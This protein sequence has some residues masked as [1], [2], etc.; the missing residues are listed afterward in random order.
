MHLS[1][2]NAL[3]SRAPANHVRVCA[4][5][6]IYVIDH[7]DQTKALKMVTTR[8]QASL[9]ARVP[10]GPRR[11]VPRNQVSE[12]ARRLHDRRAQQA[13][14][15]KVLGPVHPARP[16]PAPAAPDHSQDDRTRS[17]IQGRMVQDR[18][19]VLAPEFAAARNHHHQL[20][21]Q[22]LTA[23]PE[24]QRLED[25]LRILNLII[26]GHQTTL[27]GIAEGL[28]PEAGRPYP[29]PPYTPR[30]P[31]YVPRPTGP[32][33]HTAQGLWNAHKT[34][35]QAVAQRMG[36]VIPAL[37][38][39]SDYQ[40]KVYHTHKTIPSRQ[41]GTGIAGIVRQARLIIVP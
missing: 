31:P 12:R 14:R 15:V 18:S 39:L 28:D 17:I 7:F 38:E 37:K 25:R 26:T 32:A 8:R 13:R 6:I 5:P 33:W 24:F 30:P 10:V 3:A 19:Q 22:G 27:R 23:G 11:S 20:R 36:L 4:R 34:S 40:H 29:P 2:I 21:L 1:P 35:T 16:L 41:P 9:A